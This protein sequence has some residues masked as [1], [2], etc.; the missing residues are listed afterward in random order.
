M[1]KVK[2]GLPVKRPACLVAVC[3]LAALILLLTIR[4][5]DVYNDDTLSG[6]TLKAQGSLSDKYFKNGSFC[7]VLSDARI[8]RDDVFSSQQFNMIVKLSGEDIC[9]PDLPHM[10]SQV[11]VKGK[12]YIFD[13]ARNPGQFDLALYEKCKGIDFELTSA[14]I[15]ASGR[16]EDRLRETLNRIKYRISSVYD[17]LFGDEY[18]GIIK[19]MTL[20]DKNALDPR[21]KGLYTRAG[22]AHVLCISG[23]HISLL[24]CFIYRGLKRC[25]LPRAPSASVSLVILILYGLMTGMGIS[26][27]RALIMFLLLLLSDCIGRSYDLLSALCVSGCIILISEPYSICDTSFIMS[28]GAVTGIGIVKPAL[29][30]LFPSKNRFVD[31]LKLCVA[32]NIFSFP[33]TLYFYFQIPLYSVFLNLLIIP[34]M[35]LLLVLALISGAFGLIYLPAGVLPAK[36]AALILKIYEGVCVLNDR[37]PYSVL[38]K[39]RPNIVYIIVYYLILIISSLLITEYV[40]PGDNALK[41]AERLLVCLGISAVC[42]FIP[43]NINQNLRITM[44]D[45]GQGDCTVLETKKNRVIMIDC[46]SSDESG[47]AEYKVIPFL[48]SRGRSHIDAAVVTHADND[49]ISGFL[50]LFSL[51]ESESLPVKILYM[52]DTAL[53]DEAWK[54]LEALAESRG[55]RVVLIKTGDR[56]AADGVTFTCIHPDSGYECLDRNEYS[57]VLSVGYD[58]FSALFTGDVEGRGEE[59]VTGRI[60]HGYTLLKCAHHGSDNST[61]ED[62]LSR[63]RP[64]LTF[65]SA[66][67][68]NSYGH[69]GKEL[70][71]RLEKAGTGVFITKKSGALMLE[72]DG[73]SVD[74]KEFLK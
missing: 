16:K 19:A 74:V 3:L 23:L 33:V 50:E 22:I 15:I 31:S 12:M 63:V 25:S 57:T 71:G 72:T 49:H 66:G 7:L 46:G 65:I 54:K 18:A 61:C 55:V 59:I 24:G 48:K 67:R 35:G 53:K 70:L 4:P 58:R 5:P 36:V 1:K 38:I 73:K 26:A 44:L 6:K 37:L 45:I 41:T 11:L 2:N 30:S 60:E 20:G 51:S 32:I 69:P 52:P 43:V 14:K 9:Y 39:G 8:L 68:D 27:K 47:I 28:F 17:E 64:E 29:D 13:T 56:F 40:R 21:I 10:G 34:L 62:F 42:I